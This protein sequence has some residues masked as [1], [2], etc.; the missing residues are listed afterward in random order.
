[1][2]SA[3]SDGTKKEERDRIF[4]GIRLGDN[5]DDDCPAR[6]VVSVLF[7]GDRSTSESI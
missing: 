7:Y 3:E 6:K 1:M 2:T 5:L 4:K